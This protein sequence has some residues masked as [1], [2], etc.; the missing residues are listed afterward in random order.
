MR[1]VRLIRLMKLMGQVDFWSATPLGRLSGRV[2]RRSVF[3][4]QVKQSHVGQKLSELT[5]KRVVL[6][7]LLMVLILPFLDI[8]NT[9]YGE[10]PSYSQDGLTSL[11]NLATLDADSALFQSALQV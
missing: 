5:T 10:D 6:G 2:S 7:V 8:Q 3:T 4:P 9:I 11:H 1:V